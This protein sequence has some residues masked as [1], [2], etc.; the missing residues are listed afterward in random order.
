MSRYQRGMWLIPLAVASALLCA[1]GTPTEVRDYAKTSGAQLTT[2]SSD[3]AGLSVRERGVLDV[4]GRTTLGL[5]N[6]AQEAETGYGDAVEMMEKAPLA[7]DERCGQ[8]CAPDLLTTVINRQAE[9]RRQADAQ[10]AEQQALATL[11]ENA[12]KPTNDDQAAQVKALTAAASSAGSL[13]DEMSKEELAAF[14]FAYFKQVKS[15]FDEGQK[16]K[17]QSAASE[18]QSSTATP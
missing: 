13:A 1:C 16:Q 4:R 15:S 12:K 7:S 10:S 2:M 18:Q 8:A 5:L 17:A 6:A 11:L 9:R 14:L 3:V